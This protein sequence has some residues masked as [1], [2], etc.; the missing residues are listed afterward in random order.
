MS[1]FLKGLLLIYHNNIPILIFVLFGR[2]RFI[3]YS[4]ISLMNSIEFVIFTNT[5]ESIMNTNNKMTILLK[6]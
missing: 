6:E 4:F 1:P 3:L 5:P 2:I